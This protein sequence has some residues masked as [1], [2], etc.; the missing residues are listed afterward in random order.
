MRISNLN[1]TDLFACKWLRAPATTKI[2]S[3]GQAQAFD[4]SARVGGHRSPVELPS[5]LPD[6][7][8]QDRRN[9][10]PEERIGPGDISV[11]EIIQLREVPGDRV[12]VR[13]DRHVWWLVVR[14]PRSPACAPRRATRR[15]RH[16]ATG[17][18]P[19]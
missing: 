16:L 19:R 5:R 1:S 15:N 4:Y 12:G 9:V 6:W 10:R 17:R 2:K 18:G 14:R 7:P 11:K 13:V 3:L 8:T